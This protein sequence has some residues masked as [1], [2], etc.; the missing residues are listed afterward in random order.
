MSTTQV[1]LGPMTPVGDAQ[2]PPAITLSTDFLSAQG[3]HSPAN[4]VHPRVPTTGST[5][6]AETLPPTWRQQLRREVQLESKQIRFLLQQLGGGTTTSAP[7]LSQP[8]LKNVTDLLNFVKTQ[9]TSLAHLV[10]MGPQP[11]FKTT[12]RKL[13]RLRREHPTFATHLTFLVPSSP[14][15][16]WW[17][18]LPGTQV[19]TFW[20]GIDNS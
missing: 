10:I 8:N 1:D 4:T 13:N 19:Q 20:T 15:A 17:E 18:H 11:R 7:H 3:L 2:H 5:D 16:T 14:N 6:Q 12:L 9:G